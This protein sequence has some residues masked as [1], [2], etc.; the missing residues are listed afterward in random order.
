MDTNGQKLTTTNKK[1]NRNGNKRTKNK[2]HKKKQNNRDIIGKSD[3]NR[4]KQPEK[5]SKE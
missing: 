1:T 2:R 5:G 4:H 3:K